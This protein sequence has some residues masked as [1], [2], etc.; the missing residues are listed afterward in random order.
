TDMKEYLHQTSGST[1]SLV[2]VVAFFATLAAFGTASWMLF[3]F[4]HML[5]AKDSSR[6]HLLRTSGFSKKDVTV[7]YITSFIVVI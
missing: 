1:A 5:K 7:Q 4:L 6:N 3:M 2:K